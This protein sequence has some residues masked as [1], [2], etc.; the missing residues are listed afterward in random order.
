M[1]LFVVKQQVVRALPWYSKGFL[2]D[3]TLEMLNLFPKGAFCHAK[4]F[5]DEFGGR[6]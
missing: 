5:Y 3:L 1:H 6:C 2:V 4:C